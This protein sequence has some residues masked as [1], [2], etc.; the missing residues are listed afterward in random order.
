MKKVGLFG[1]RVMSVGLAASLLLAPVSANKCFAV[2]VT[3]EDREADKKQ[4]QMPERLYAYS[5]KV[6]PQAQRQTQQQTLRI[7]DQPP[8]IYEKVPERY[9]NNK[10]DDDTAKALALI[11]TFGI[12]IYGGK[13]CWDT[14]KSWELPDLSSTVSLAKSLSS[15]QKE[16]V[17]DFVS[18]NKTLFDEFKES[19][20]FAGGS[21]ANMFYDILHMM[22]S[23]VS[24][25]YYFGK[26]IFKLGQ[27]AFSKAL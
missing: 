19:M 27:V 7:Y 8:T 21:V 2:L 14:V 13:W 5:E 17:M 3:R 24:F 22:C 1:K 16:Y 12:F 23:G 25:Y 4:D 9:D 11:I 15:T 18:K 10:G 6:Q 20:K 26:A